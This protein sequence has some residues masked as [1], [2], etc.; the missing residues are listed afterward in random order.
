MAGD[1]KGRFYNGFRGFRATLHPSRV[2][3]LGISPPKSHHYFQ[4]KGAKKRE[5]AGTKM[6]LIAGGKAEDVAD[7]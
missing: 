7:F 1:G 6:G 2:T 5:G 3:F 4:R